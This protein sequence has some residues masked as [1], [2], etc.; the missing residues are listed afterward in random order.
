LSTSALK[1]RRD[2]YV[3]LAGP[4]SQKTGSNG[5]ELSIWIFQRR[6]CDIRVA[7]RTADA[8]PFFVRAFT[9]GP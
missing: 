3:G 1:M 2:R 5:N 4:T 9:D 7:D 6:E 8:L